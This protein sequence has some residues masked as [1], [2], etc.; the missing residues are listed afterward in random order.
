MVIEKIPKHP[1]IYAIMFIVYETL[2][3]DTRIPRNATEL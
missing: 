3:K 1:E 2:V